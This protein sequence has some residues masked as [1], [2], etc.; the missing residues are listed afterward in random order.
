MT[1]ASMAALAA[2]VAIEVRTPYETVVGLL[3]EVFLAKQRRF[4]SY[5]DQFRQAWKSAR[6]I[7]L[8]SNGWTE[9]D[10]YAEM[11]RRRKALH[12]PDSDA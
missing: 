3:E 9:R 12:F 11:D 4:P 1:P 6:E 8:D 10:F 7:V 5:G 2:D